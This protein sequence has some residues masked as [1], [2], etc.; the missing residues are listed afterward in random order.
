[1]D[2]VKDSDRDSVRIRVRVSVSVTLYSSVQSPA[3][4]LR[5]TPVGIKNN[6]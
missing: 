2:S 4:T 3:F 5:S 6:I 1:M